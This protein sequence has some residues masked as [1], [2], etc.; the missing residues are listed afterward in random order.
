MCAHQPT[1]T[2]N[3]MNDDGRGFKLRSLHYEW[4]TPLLREKQCDPALLTSNRA[5]EPDWVVNRRVAEAN[6][7]TLS[8][9]GLC[10]LVSVDD[11]HVQHEEGC[12]Q[13]SEDCLKWC[14]N[15]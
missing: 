8:L 13:K 7:A 14:R 12:Y 9:G 1:H 6:D 5:S 2:H 11:E 3:Y 4:H 10:L 15:H